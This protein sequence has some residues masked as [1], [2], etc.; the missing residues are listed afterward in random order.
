M[1]EA[2]PACIR[3]LPGLRPLTARPVFADCSGPL[4]PIAPGYASL[5]STG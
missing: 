5:T 2:V 4:P 1:G 3:S